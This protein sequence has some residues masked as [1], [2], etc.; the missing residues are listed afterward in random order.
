[1]VVGLPSDDKKFSNFREAREAAYEECI[2]PTHKLIDDAITAG[3]THEMPF[4]QPGDV[5][6]RDYSDVRALQEDQDK[7]ADRAGKLYKVGLIKRKTGLQMVG[8]EYDEIE[9]DVYLTDLIK[10]GTMKDGDQD[11]ERMEGKDL[12]SVRRMIGANWRSRIPKHRRTADQKL[13]PQKVG[14]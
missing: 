9:D 5:L 14:E 13:L 12:A 1:M 4:A 8:E 11:G 6:G 2:I 7:L 3:T 10:P